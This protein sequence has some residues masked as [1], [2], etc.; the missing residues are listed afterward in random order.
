M[1]PSCL[2]TAPVHILVVEDEAVLAL[3]LTDLLEAEGY[4]VVGAAASGPEALALF[5]QHLPDLVLCDIR[6][7]GPW[8]GIETVGHLLAERQVPIIYLT[9][10]ADR[11]TL[12]RALPTG[13]AAYLDKPVRVAG[14]RAAIE[15]ALRQRGPTAAAPPAAEAALAAAKP[16]ETAAR[17]TLL[18]LD[19][20]V[21][22]K[23]NYQFVRVD[24]A[25]LLL[26]EANNTTITLLT[27][28]PRYS[29]RLSLTAALERLH[30]PP[31]VRVH[32]SY[33]LNLAHVSAFS[34]TEAVVGGLSVPI[35]RQYKADFLRQFTTY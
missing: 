31:L 32:R 22:L 11:D 34:E 16:E 17:E 2:P 5:R 9:A 33:A 15:V 8:D 20:H 19:T 10:M 18:R 29:L 4:V 7:Q 12:A 3:D 23:H 24:L 26:L 35:G 28:G 27:T 14:L 1:S 13:P 21:F 6:L 25:D 30:Y